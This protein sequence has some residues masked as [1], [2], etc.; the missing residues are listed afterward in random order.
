VTD[1]ATRQQAAE[2]AI[3]MLDCPW[4]IAKAGEPC[5]ADD[6]HGGVTRDWSST[7]TGRFAGLGSPADFLAYGAGGR[8]TEN[9]DG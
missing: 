7:H 9:G 3:K 8:G 2:L 5:F 4:C 1:F 6:G